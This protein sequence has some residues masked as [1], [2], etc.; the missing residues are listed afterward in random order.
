M[1]RTTP[2][3]RSPA[4][5]GTALRELR[6]AR[7]VSL[8]SLAKRIEVSPATLS[9]IEN[10][11]TRLS[12]ARY[13]QLADALGISWSQVVLNA[14]Y[15]QPP[16]DNEQSANRAALEELRATTDWRE[17]EIMHVGPILLAAS[18]VFAESGYEG[19][20]MRSIAE[21]ANL[22]VAG[23]YHHYQSKQELLVRLFE[24]ATVDLERRFELVLATESAPAQRLHD[25]AECLSH[26][27]ARRSAFGLLFLL[28]LR[29]LEG[30][31]ADDIEAR[32]ARL[33]G[34]I[35]ETVEAGVATGEFTPT[36]PE[37]VA[38]AIV[39][40]CTSLSLWYRRTAEP[41]TPEEISRRYADMA[42]DLVR[43]GR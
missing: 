26:F 18:A 38:R 11:K 10:G 4:D 40:L 41:V 12:V 8:R 31:T 27:H 35:A 33:L 2:H 5:L 14:I 20:T 22:S 13:R 9:A 25:L 28:E 15:E 32:L 16:V 24:M 21:A 6:E 42:L 37:S 39:S 17:F 30:D 34:A 3:F 36:H 7:G 43:A 1:E 23:I 19:A 29:S